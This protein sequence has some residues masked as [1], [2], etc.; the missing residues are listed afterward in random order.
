[1]STPV[2]RFDH[3][4]VFLLLGNMTFLRAGWRHT[5]C[6][7]LDLPGYSM[8]VFGSMWHQAERTTY[9]QGSLL[10]NILI[11]KSS[12]S[13][14]FGL[15]LTGSP[16][17]KNYVVFSPIV[18]VMISSN[19]PVDDSR[20]TVA[21]VLVCTIWLIGLRWLTG[22]LQTRLSSLSPCFYFVWMAFG[23]LDLF[24]A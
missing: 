20:F 19:S 15:A 17:D 23:A 6:N 11:M 21:S 13:L 3:W 24:R 18:W 22:N 8:S 4:W 10:W 5:C 1:M 12:P 7:G 14:G 16:I 9:G 2:S